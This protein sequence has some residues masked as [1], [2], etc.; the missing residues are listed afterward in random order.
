MK[1]HQMDITT[2]YLSDIVDEEIHMEVPEF[3]KKLLPEII[4]D[5]EDLSLQAVA[6]GML[7]D[8]DNKVCL[9]NKALYRL[10]QIG[11]Q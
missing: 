5:C 4:E 7:W 1:M 8:S 11:R 10:K 3:L 9:L 6:Q 2:A